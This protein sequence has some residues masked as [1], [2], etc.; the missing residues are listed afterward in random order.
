M[1]MY[2]SGNSNKSD[3]KSQYLRHSHLGH[4]VDHVI[5]MAVKS[6]SEPLTE[7]ARWGEGRFDSSCLKKHTVILIIQ[8]GFN[9]F[10]KWAYNGCYQQLVH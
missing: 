7:W 3:C 5:C 10:Y 9:G 4:V 8:L 6:L 1:H 2:Y